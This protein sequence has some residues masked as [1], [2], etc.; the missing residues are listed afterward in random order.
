MP[1][2]TSNKWDWAL[3]F[4]ELYLI[5]RA[6]EK[7]EALMGAIFRADHFEHFTPR[8]VNLI[9]QAAMQEMFDGLL[10]TYSWRSYL[11]TMALAVGSSKE[12][13]L[14]GHNLWCEG[15]YSAT[16]VADFLIAAVYEEWQEKHRV[17]HSMD[18]LTEAKHLGSLA[19]H[20]HKYVKSKANWSNDHAA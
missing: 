7:G 17:S 6:S 13:E 5:K 10:G 15:H 18:Q 3:P 20:H 2:H 8:A 11:P 9:T 14:R 19:P 4:L 12:G 16:C 1:S